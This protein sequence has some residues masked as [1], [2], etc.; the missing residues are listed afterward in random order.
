MDGCLHVFVVPKRLEKPFDSDTISVI[1]NFAKLS[2]FEK[3]LLLSKPK[4][5]FESNKPYRK[6][7]PRRLERYSDFMGCLYQLTE[8]EKPYFKERIDPRDLFRI[9]VIEPQQ[10]FERIRTQSEAFLISAFHERF[11]RDEIIKW[12]PDIPVYGNYKL[13]VPTAKKQY[14]MEELRLL[15]VT[16]EVL[17][18]GLDESAKAIDQ[19]ARPVLGKPLIDIN[20]I[21]RGRL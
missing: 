3:D 18:P 19:L 14:I 7:T 21:V 16:R 2:S 9:F 5:L 6:M 1:T 15:N 20:E 4:S 8:Q 17:F 11:E 10:S 13:V 12:N